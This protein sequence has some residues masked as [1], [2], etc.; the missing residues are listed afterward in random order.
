MS[1]LKVL[2]VV[3]GI[4]WR[5]G[6]V[7]ATILPMCEALARRPGM[8]VEIATTD[9]DG[10][11]GRLT[12]QTVP[13]CGVPIRMFRR[14]FSERWKFS[15]G[16]FRWLWRHGGNYDLLHV[17]G[18]WGFSMAAACTASRR[19]GVP[20][21]ILP[22]GMLSLYSWTQSPWHK[23]LYWGLLE[24]RNV[25]KATRLLLTSRGEGLEMAGLGLP[26]PISY[27][28][29]GL[30]EDAWAT[31]PWPGRLRELCEGRDRGRPI[32]LFMSRLHPKKGIID[33]LLPALKLLSIDAFLVIAGGRDPHAPGYA[34][35]VPRAIKLL[36]LQDRVHLLGPIEPEDRWSIFDGA[37]VFVLPSR[38]ENFGLVVTEAMA[39]GV[40]VV[41]SREAYSCE[42][43]LA[44]DAGRVVP[45]EN[46]AITAA[47]DELLAATIQLVKPWG[48][49][50]D[51]H[52]QEPELG[53]NCRD[54]P[55]HVP[56]L[57]GRQ[58]HPKTP[59]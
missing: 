37:D 19:H 2:H 5:Y 36:G 32:V 35:E 55:G 54:D 25:A 20:L 4:A 10:P 3:G 48:S 22:H 28:P 24:R 13:R 31:P 56:P 12:P 23:N 9:A 15:S 33:F 30:G 46:D 29:L 6:G 39:R 45:L 17:H 53:P 7:T 18:V 26:T 11:R 27:I 16:L 1:E 51:L 47:V 8:R 40:P 50:A 38:Q 44:A 59:K 21:V 14:D 52:P 42:H 49:G 57:C 34:E 58:P 43:V 41:V